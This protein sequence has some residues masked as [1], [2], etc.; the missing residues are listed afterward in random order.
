M[1]HV[2]LIGGSWDLVTTYNEAQNPTCNRGRPY[3]HIRLLGETISGVM[4]PVTSVVQKSPE[5]PSRPK[6]P[7]LSYTNP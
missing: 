3:N 1:A 6:P 5:P 7:N 4:S 2:A